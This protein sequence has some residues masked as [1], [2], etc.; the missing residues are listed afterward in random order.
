MINFNILK[1]RILRFAIYHKSGL[2]Q[3]ISFGCGILIAVVAGN[4][5]VFNAYIVFP[6]L[7]FTLL[8]FVFTLKKASEFDLLRMVILGAGTASLIAA[9]ITFISIGQNGW[10][11]I[12]INQL[13]GLFKSILLT[14]FFS[15]LERLARYREDQLKKQFSQ[16]V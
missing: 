15:L 13:A 2:K 8:T 3:V 6:I 12:D 14:S 1:E 4:F 10:I 11:S 16:V 5:T 7:A 9:F